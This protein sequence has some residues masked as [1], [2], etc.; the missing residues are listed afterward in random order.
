MLEPG[1]GKQARDHAAPRDHG[2]ILPLADLAHPQGP[3]LDVP[4]PTPAHPFVAAQRRFDGT[5]A[6]NAFG[7][8]HRVLERHASAL[9]EI[10]CAWVRRVAKQRDASASPARQRRK[11]VSAI[12]ED[13]FGGLDQGWNRL[14][15]SSKT[16]KKLALPLVRENGIVLRQVGRRV[17]RKFVL[18]G[19]EDA[20]TAAMSPRFAVVS[21]ADRAAGVA[22][23]RT[24]RA[25]SS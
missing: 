23:G 15:P 24:C 22:D 17:P 10:R 14:V 6:R 5:F 21:R 16:L 20:E 13:A 7:E 19:T 12:F 1:S 25:T 4:G 9:P 2:A 18:S 3:V 11:I 8:H